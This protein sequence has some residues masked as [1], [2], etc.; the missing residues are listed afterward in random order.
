MIGGMASGASLLI[1]GVLGL[2]AG[3]WGTRQRHFVVYGLMATGMLALATFGVIRI[4]TEMGTSMT[5]KTFSHYWDDAPD[6]SIL[7]IQEMGECCG[8]EDYEDRVQEPC[9]E[10]VERLGCWEAIIRP[11]HTRLLRQAFIP[12]TII[13]ALLLIATLLNIAMALT[14]RRERESKRWS[15]AQRQP[16]DA[17]HK[18]VFQ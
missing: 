18:A 12:C 7:R 3:H 11:A 4:K 2:Y 9:T 5:K 10:Y 14:I 8:F 16:F 1:L 6:S 13:T 17:W 15:F